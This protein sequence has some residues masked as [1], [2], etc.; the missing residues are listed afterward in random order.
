MEG[1]FQVIVNLRSAAVE[2]SAEPPENRYGKVL[3]SDQLTVE[4]FEEQVAT[5][6]EGQ[7]YDLRD[8]LVQT[9]GEFNRLLQNIKNLM[10]LQIRK[11]GQDVFIHPEDISYVTLNATGVFREI[12]DELE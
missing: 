12:L 2:F 10:Y 3:R 4:F 8:L 7:E 9:M 11:G 6:L 5:K 1:T